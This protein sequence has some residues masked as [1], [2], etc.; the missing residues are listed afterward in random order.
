MCS[1]SDLSTRC[2]ALQGYPADQASQ[3][4]REAE[5]EHQF[6]WLSWEST[7]MPVMFDHLCYF[8]AVSVLLPPAYVY[9]A[10]VCYVAEVS[11]CPQ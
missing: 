1:N 5:K 10:P 8:K 9:I 6:R 3:L 2:A 7:V 4:V 11:Y